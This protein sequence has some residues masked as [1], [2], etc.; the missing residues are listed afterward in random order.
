M[1]DLNHAYKLTVI[2]ASQLSDIE[3][4]NASFFDDLE[5]LTEITDLRI[6][7]KVEKHLLKIPNQAEIT[8]TNLSSRSRDDLVRGPTKCRLEAG[9]D[10]TGPRLLF[11]GDTRSAF[12]E[13]TGT[14]WITK[15]QLAD[16]GRAYAEARHNRSYAKGTPLTTVMG[17][18]AKAFGTSLPDLSKFS[19]LQSRIATGEVVT[20]YVADELTR[21][22]DPFGMGWSFQGG[23]L[24]IMRTDGVIAS[25]A[26]EIS[27]DTGMIGAPV[28]DP[29]KLR[30][31]RKAGRRGG[32]A[33]EQKVPKMKVKH[34][35]YPEVTP[36]ERLDVQSRG[37]T[38]IFRCDVVTHT[39]DSEGTG[40]DSWITHIEGRHAI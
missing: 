7:F 34:V 5:T 31:P 38:G 24:Q 11:I 39:G 9:Y 32:K 33:G 17:D 19:E 4:L 23:R 29:P 10:D 35:M 16:G 18:L 40:Q 20:G 14:E 36:G 28:I 2:S 37:V 15:L 1:S 30:A 6:Q 21:L 3:G 13:H 26:R 27:A 8:L 22:L 25:E 12:S